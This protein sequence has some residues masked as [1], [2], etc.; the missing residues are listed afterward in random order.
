LRMNWP[1]KDALSKGILWLVIAIS[2]S[3]MTLGVM[4][5]MD[6]YLIMNDC[7][8]RK[9][10][11]WG[12]EQPGQVDLLFRSKGVFAANYPIDV[13]VKV[14]PGDDIRPYF[15]SNRT[16]RL[17]ILGSQEYDGHDARISGT[18]GY[19]LIPT[20]TG[21]GKG[22]IIFQYAGSYSKCLIYVDDV[23]DERIKIEPPL[24]EIES[25]AARWEM[26]VQS[27]TLGVALFAASL[28]LLDFAFRN[29][30]K[31]TPLQVQRV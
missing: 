4:V 30:R 14:I 6:P 29:V 2:V 26:E 15:E 10:F 21:I 17:E 11:T 20:A 28:A 24:I 19:V 22:T 8:A 1:R 12:Y 25:Y 27:R 16:I 31:T 5:A 9:S 13:E 7:I 23:I 18:T 3:I